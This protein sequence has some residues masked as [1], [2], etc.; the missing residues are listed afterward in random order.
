MFTGATFG[1]NSEILMT[2]STSTTVK[3]ALTS[4]PGLSCA[5]NMLF[6]DVREFDERVYQADST[7]QSARPAPPTG[8]TVTVVP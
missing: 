4:N 3:Y 2:G 7:V 5:G 8:L 6:P 1:G